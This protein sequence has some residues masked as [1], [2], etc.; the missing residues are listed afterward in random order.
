MLATIGLACLLALASGAGCNALQFIVDIPG[1]LTISRM[2]PIATP[3]E[4]S[5][6]VHRI[7]GASNFNGECLLGIGV[8]RDSLMAKRE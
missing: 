8:R 4:I 6:H 2:D 3:G 5:G 7:V 1:A